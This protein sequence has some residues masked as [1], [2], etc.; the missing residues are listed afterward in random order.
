MNKVLS[1]NRDLIIIAGMILVSLV[2]AKNLYNQQIDKYAKMKQEIKVEEEKGTTLDRIIL[3]NERLK[4]IK[5]KSWDTVDSNF[6]IDKIFNIAL[7]SQI[8]I[9]SITPQDKRDEKNYAA[10]PFSLSGEAI[11]RDLLKFIKRLE[12]YKMMLRVKDLSMNPIES[13]QSEKQDLL[14]SFSLLVEAIYF[15]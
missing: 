11:Y 9:R 3:L 13:Q 8:K 2:I 14:L 12:T 5:E 15:K 4:K 10:I 7:E 1:K 6:I